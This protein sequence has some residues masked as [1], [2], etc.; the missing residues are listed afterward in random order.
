MHMRFSRSAITTLAIGTVMAAGVAGAQ[1]AAASPQAVTLAVP[2]N[3]GA[4]AGDISAAVSGET[5]H[6]APSCIY[7]L[8]EALPDISA[9]ITI[10]GGPSTIQ[11]SYAGGTPEFSLFTVDSDVTLAL[12]GVSRLP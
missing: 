4:L 8:S 2:C 3:A 1:G 12:A 10:V 7:V 11:R 9:D 6:L 5:L